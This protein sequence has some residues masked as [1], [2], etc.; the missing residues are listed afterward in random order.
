MRRLAP[1]HCQ[2]CTVRSSSLFCDLCAEFVEELDQAKST[3]QY[4]PRQIIFYEGNDPLGVYCVARGKVKLYKTDV[5]GHQQ[6]LRLAGNGDVIGYRSVVAQ[7]PHSVTAETMEEAKICFIDKATFLHIFERHPKTAFRVTSSL[8]KELRQSGD[9][10]INLAH[11]NTR[12][13]L[14]EVL[15]LLK[16]KFGQQDPQGIKLDLSLS[17]QELANMIGTTQE[18]VVR[19]LSEFKQEGTIQVDRRQITL[20]NTAKLTEMANLPL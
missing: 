3:N 14:A 2:N 1:Q 17:R 19:L 13:R 8:G 15:L 18:S 16:G 9:Q 5:E 6:I 20:L 10:V 11:K 7:E 4:K 12:E